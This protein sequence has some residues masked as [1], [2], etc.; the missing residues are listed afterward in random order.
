MAV[1]AARERQGH[2][3]VTANDAHA[4][5]AHAHCLLDAVGVGVG[6]GK[7][8]LASTLARIDSDGWI[9]PARLL[10]VVVFNT[11]YQFSTFAKS[12]Q[13]R[14]EPREKDFLVRLTYGGA[15]AWRGDAPAP[16]FLFFYLLYFM[17]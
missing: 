14:E 5:L 4:H 8:D 13:Q 6:R 1:D 2:L 15:G 3:D 12:F 9:H 16:P 7:A 17:A 10:L 11:Q